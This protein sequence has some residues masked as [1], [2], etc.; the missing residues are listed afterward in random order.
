MKTPL[1]P[2]ATPEPDDDIIDLDAEP[3]PLADGDDADAA[4]EDSAASRRIEVH[5]KLRTRL[6]VFLFNRLKGIS[7]SKIQKLIDLGG[8]SVNGAVPKASHKVHEGDVVD[9]ILPPPAVRRIEPEPIPLDVIYE[10]DQFIVINKQADLIVH[11]AR[12][13]LSGTLI[14]GL[15]WRFKQQV[16]KAGGTFVHRTTRGFKEKGGPGDRQPPVTSPQQA[17]KSSDPDASTEA[18][19]GIVAGLSSVGAQEFRPGIIHRL[20]RFTTGVMVVAKADTAHWAIAR[21]FEDRTTH[22][23][24]LALVHGN[25]E[26]H[27]GAVEYPIG[28]HPTIREA[29]AVRHDSSGKY[30]L[31]LFRVREQYKGYALVEME[32]KTGRTHQ[33]RVHMAYLGHPIVGDILYGGEPIGKPELDNPPVPMGPRPFVTFARDKAQGQRVEDVA[34]KRT[35]MILA[36]PALHAAMLS[37]THPETRQRVTFTAPLHEPMRSLIHE[38]RSRRV[39]RPVATEGYWV[40]LKQAVPE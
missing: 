37:F 31:T 35:D 20:D 17:P 14:N 6:D 30:A 39:D 28:K 27:G 38:L 18:E 12:S 24:Y 1:P 23:C 11:P 2:H 19:E 40:D 9:V 7:R 5:S 36:R 22:K 8:V 3:A 25:L 29:M 21:Q 33:I 13:H 32:I 15:A 4:P 34:A 26:T 16:E 10:D